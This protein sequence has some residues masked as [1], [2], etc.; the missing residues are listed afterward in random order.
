MEDDGLDV[1]LESPDLL[2]INKPG[3]LLTQAPIE[4]DS[5]ERRLRLSDWV[6]QSETRPYV[7]IPH[8]LDRPASGVILFG[9]NKKATRFVADQFEKRTVEKTYWALLEGTVEPGHG[10]WLDWMK[11]CEDQ[12][13]SVVVEQDDPDALYASLRYEV[14][15]LLG[16]SSLVSIKLETGRTHQIRLQSSSR[17]HPIWG[18]EMYGAVRPFGPVE[19]DQRL[20]WIALH[21]R[22]IALIEP[23]SKRRIEIVAPLP[24]AWREVPELAGIE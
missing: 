23:S 13:Q 9:R 17:K 4:V 24:A 11:K 12:P 20:R 2:A 15:T 16:D 18:D 10:R 8:R 1:I 3:G 6:D 19:T 7:G 21:A 22:S 5:L 14:V